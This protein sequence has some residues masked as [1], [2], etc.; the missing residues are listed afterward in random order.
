[1]LRD[2]QETRRPLNAPSGLF[3]AVC[4]FRAAGDE[5]GTAGEVHHA[6]NLF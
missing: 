1:M 4:S 6:F 5:R 3:S 2:A